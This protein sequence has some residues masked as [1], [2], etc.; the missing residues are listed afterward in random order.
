MRDDKA[1]QPYVSY[2]FVFSSDLKDWGV[3]KAR[4]SRSKTREKERTVKFSKGR[5]G[6]L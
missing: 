2:A 4:E 5:A 1:R 3:S 6:N